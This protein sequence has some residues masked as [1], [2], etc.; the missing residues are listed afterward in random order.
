MSIQFEADQ[1]LPPVMA[2]R[3]RLRQIV[4]NLMENS[5]NYTPVDGH[6]TLS[7]A[8]QE[9]HILVQIADDGIGISPDDSERVFERFFRGEQAL[10]MSVAGTGLGLSIVRQLVEMH[11]GSISLESS[12][13][14]G[15]GTTFK[16][17]LPIADQATNKVEP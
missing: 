11:G 15:E 16:F 5:F 6:I 14:P 8:K 13:N 4:G 7:A 17:S 2:D 12:G 3:D 10:N 1:S 9:N